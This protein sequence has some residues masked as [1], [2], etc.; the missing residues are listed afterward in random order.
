MAP[1]HVDDHMWLHVL[2]FLLF[3]GRLSFLQHDA[4][5]KYANIKYFGSV[6]KCDMTTYCFT[7]L[8]LATITT[9]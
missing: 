3:F 6:H 9:Y 4:N 7:S 2:R 8:K 5:I 1:H